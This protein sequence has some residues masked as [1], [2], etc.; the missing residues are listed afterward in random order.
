M[1]DYVRL[2]HII[3]YNISFTCIL[4][5]D[6]HKT[7]KGNKIFQ[8]YSM[9]YILVSYILQVVFYKLYSTSYIL[10]AIFYKLYSTSYILQVIFYKLYS[11]SYIL[12]VIFY[13]I[14][15]K[16]YILKVIFYKLYYNPPLETLNIQDTVSSHT[17]SPSYIY[18]SP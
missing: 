3:P 2:W 7:F 16:S 10:Q 9:K 13:K 6:L 17:C 18:M 5:S 8:L 12:Q 11:T 14:Y 4:K 1:T 15:S